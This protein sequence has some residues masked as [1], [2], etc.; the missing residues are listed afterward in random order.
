VGRMIVVALALAIV[1]LYFFSDRIGLSSSE[2]SIQQT[3]GGRAETE[4]FI[5]FYPDTLFKGPRLEQVVQLHEFYYAQVAKVLWIRP[6]KKIQSYIYATPGQKGRLI[7][8]ANTDIAK[9][10][11]WQLHIN[12]GDI[13]AS[14]RHELV[15]VMAADFGFPLLR[16]GVNSGLTEGLATAVERV[17]YE[18]PVHRLA[19]MVFATGAAPDMQSLFSLSGFMKAP[20]GVSYTLAGSFCRYLIDRYGMRRFKLLYR[21]GEFSILYGKPLPLLLQE[22]RRSLD[23]FH[24]GDGDVG[25]ANYLFKRQSIFGKEC[26]RV[27]ANMNTETRALLADRRFEDALKSAEKSLGKTMST[28]AVYQKT[29]ALIRLGKYSD[30]IAFAQT[31]LGDSTAASSFLTLNSLLGDALW[32]ADSLEGAMR[33][34]GELLRAHLSLVWDES[35]ALRQEIM[36]KPILARAL[37]PLFLSSMAD[38]VRLFTL[39]NLV[40]TFPKEPIPRHLLAREKASR[41]HY[42]EAIQLLDGMRTFDSPILELARQRRLAQLSMAVGHYQKSKLY[43]WQSL[44]HVYRETQSLEIEEKLRFCDWMDEFGRQP[45]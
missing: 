28:E 43:Y 15:H 5:V 13:D 33:V 45:N 7:G 32:G 37:R 24:F 19:A 4:H 16:I 38:S 41:E 1:L 18:E 3:L 30:A 39:E 31:R 6:G 34:Y 21:T 29:T 40:Q 20:A 26:A 36:L 27:I 12:A 11:L 2:P 42:E 10:W 44:N 9:P 35:T 17:E 23:H 22:W 14:L 25:K 8:A